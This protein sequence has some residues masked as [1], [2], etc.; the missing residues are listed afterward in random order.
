MSIFKKIN[1]QNSS[2]VLEEQNSAEQFK[3]GVNFEF[4]YGVIEDLDSA[5][6]WYT[7]SAEQGNIKA[8]AYLAWIYFEG[9]GIAKDYEKSVYWYSK[10][11]KQGD[12]NAKFELLQISN[13]FKK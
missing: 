2:P 1:T 7:K 11:A 12:E 13:L 9:K 6:Y 5:I 8:Q 3:C 4:G 10:A